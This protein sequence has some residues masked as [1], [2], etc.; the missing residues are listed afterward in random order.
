MLLHDRHGDVGASSVPSHY[1]AERRGQAQPF[2]YGTFALALTPQPTDDDG[3]GIP[4]NSRC[5]SNETGR[6]D[7]EKALAAA[8][9]LSASER[10]MLTS[11]RLALQP[12]CG[13]GSDMRSVVAKAVERCHLQSGP[14]ICRLSARGGRLLRWRFCNGAHAVSGFGKGIGGMAEGNGKLYAGPGRAQSGDGERL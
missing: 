4:Y 9:G 14:R 8:K 1:A 10:G 3:G 5:I 2:A 12:E 6:L 13:E 11:A 7:F